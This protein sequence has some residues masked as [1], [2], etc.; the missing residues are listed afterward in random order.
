MGILNLPLTI[1]VFKEGTSKKDPY[2]AYNPELDVSSCGKTEEEARKMLEE[3]VFLI[4]KGAK[5]DGTL[6]QVLE[7]A[8]FKA[9]SHEAP[10]TYFSVFTF[11]LQKLSRG[12]VS[13]A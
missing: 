1:K 7:E 6:N 5:E 10:K 4:L 9:N 3:A 2:V 11:P 13:Y 12:K 8:G